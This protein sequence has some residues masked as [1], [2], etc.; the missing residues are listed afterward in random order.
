MA[1]KFSNTKRVDMTSYIN[2][3]KEMVDS[4]TWN[5]D[6][7]ED[8]IAVKIKDFG[9]CNYFSKEFPKK[10]K[11]HEICDI[12]DFCILIYDS[13]FIAIDRRIKTL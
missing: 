11:M 12:S 8:Q 1:K 10:I 2:S 5:D 3:A 4:S 9:H 7:P 6:I 13:R